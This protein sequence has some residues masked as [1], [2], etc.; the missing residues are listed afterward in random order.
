MPKDE[1]I[2][3]H[4][5]I[6]MSLDGYIARNDHA[7]DWLP[8]EENKGEDMGYESFMETIDVLVMGSSSFKNILSFGIE[9]PYKKPVFILSKSLDESSIPK[10]LKEC[11]QISNQTPKDLM[12][13]LFAKGLKRVYVDGGL[14]VQSFIKD[15][16]IK[17]F[18]ITTIPILI[19]EGR[20]LFGQTNSDIHLKLIR[21]KAFKSG[22]VQNHY[23]I[24][25]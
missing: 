1:K 19:G 11:V 3:G 24:L 12:K 17:D 25:S 4:V 7:L 9:W 5:F 8:Q 6:A 16:L 10:E 14:V 2:T 23:E 15:D 20:K 13:S 18:I 22:I 21:S